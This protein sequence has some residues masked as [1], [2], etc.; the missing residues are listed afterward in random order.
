MGSGQ[1]TVTGRALVAPRKG[2]PVAHCPRRLLLRQQLT[3]PPTT[4]LSLPLSPLPAYRTA[5]AASTLLMTSTAQLSPSE[6]MIPLVIQGDVAK[7]H[8]RAGFSRVGT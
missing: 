2:R 4:C 5:R 8:S 1:A 3:R 7:I 6:W